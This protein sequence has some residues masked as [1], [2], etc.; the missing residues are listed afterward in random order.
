MSDL[1]VTVS[2]ITVGFHIEYE[3]DGIHHGFVRF[4]NHP[5]F[6]IALDALGDPI[7][8][9]VRGQVQSHAEAWVQRKVKEIADGDT[10]SEAT[11][12]DAP[13]S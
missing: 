12:T 13:D 9:L 5:S 11:P 7:P 2:D 1:K 8:D 3:A 6:Q 4:N 10:R